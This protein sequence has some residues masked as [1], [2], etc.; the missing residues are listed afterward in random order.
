MFDTPVGVVLAVAGAAVAIVFLV[1]AAQA[2]HDRVACLAH[3]SMG[4]GMIGM[5]DPAVDVVSS[6][7]GLVVFVLITV[8]FLVGLR[9]GGVPAGGRVEGIHLVVAPAAMALMYVLMISTTAAGPAA[10]THRGD[11]GAD[12]ADTGMSPGSGGMSTLLTVLSIVLVAYFVGYAAVLVARLVRRPSAAGIGDAVMDE[13]VIT[14][15]ESGAGAAAP[16]ITRSGLATVVT[17]AHVAM[18]LLMAVMFL[19]AV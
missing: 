15:G 4:L 6:T 11:A 19:G 9:R 8:W 18:C 14:A 16:T 5:F 17:L 12:G 3:G 7:V 2:R 13:P 1:A 10:M